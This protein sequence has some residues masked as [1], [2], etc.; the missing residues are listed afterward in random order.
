MRT[1]GAISRV[2][3]HTLAIAASLPTLRT[4]RPVRPHFTVPTRSHSFAF[5]SP[6][7]IKYTPCLTWPR[8]GYPTQE[9]P[10]KHPQVDKLHPHGQ[11]N[12]AHGTPP[13]APQPKAAVVPAPYA[14]GQHRPPAFPITADSASLY[15]AVPFVG[16]SSLIIP[17]DAA[18]ASAIQYHN[19]LLPSAETFSPPPR[20]AVRLSHPSS[21]VTGHAC[22]VSADNSAVPGDFGIL[23]MHQGRGR[24]VSIAVQRPD[25][26]LAG[27]S[28]GVPGHGKEFVRG[29]GRGRVRHS[30][31]DLPRLEPH[32]FRYPFQSMQL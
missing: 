27:R 21:E 4:S 29:H 10:L 12:V 16:S 31:S 32:T 3:A 9:C 19:P 23:G 8:C 11:P 20:V 5:S 18:Y 26:E 7:D 1:A 15:D 17:H 24:R 6:T 22:H 30:A 14:G 25:V 13:I 28:S 2:F